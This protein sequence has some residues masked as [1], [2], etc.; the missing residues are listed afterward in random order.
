MMNKKARAG[1]GIMQIT[2]MLVAVFAFAFIIN[3]GIVGAVVT[4]GGRGAS[5]LAH[6]AAHKVPTTPTPTGTGGAGGAAAESP[7]L[8]GIKGFFTNS[9]VQGVLWGAT[10]AIIVLAIG[11]AVD[12][13]FES[14]RA[15]WYGAAAGG[16][17]GAGVA[18]AT[19]LSFIGW[20]G[21]IGAAIAAVVF[22][23]TS[24][25][26][27]KTE[28]VQF[29]CY[30]WQA[31]T[32]GSDC[33]KCNEN[34]P[35]VPCSEYRCKSLGQMCGIVNA[36]TED[37]K[38]IYMGRESL[39]PGIAPWDEP[40][41]AGYE[42]AEVKERPEGSGSGSSGMKIV[43]AGGGCIDAF[44]AITFGIETSEPAQC[45]IDYKHTDNF[46]AMGYYL[47]EDNLFKTQHEQ[48]VSLPGTKLLNSLYPEIENDGEY[49]LFIRCKDGN[50]NG[51]GNENIDEFVVSFCVDDTPDV[52]PPV[53]KSTSIENNA[54]VLFEVDEVDVSLF[55]NE[56]AE[57]R[58]DRQDTSFENMKN[59]SVS[60][61]SEVW[62]MNNDLLYPCS[63]TLTGVEDRVDNNFYFRCQDLNNNTMQQSYKYVLKGTQP[64]DILKVGPNKTVGGS[65]SV[66]TV[67]LE[68]RTDNG[69]N[70]GESTCGYS[71][72]GVEGSYVEM[73]ETGGNVHK[74]D[75]DLT[76]GDYDIYY[77]CVDLGGNSAEDQVSFEV[78]VDER[79][80]RVV[81]AYE[82]NSKLKIVTNEKAECRYGSEQCNY[83][84]EEGILMVVGDDAEVTHYAE[85]K[86]GD[87]YYIK[88]SDEFGNMPATSSCSI[89]VRPSS[90]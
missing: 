53:I 78:D 85:W 42:Y 22:L 10:V 46:D 15:A 55:I 39:S 48:A 43:K 50:E 44:T 79:A 5:T 41:T 76:D 20:A 18:V 86:A 70:N 69:F 77:K 33:E 4:E 71:F 27:A 90:I 26:K 29:K 19:S 54:P 61:S 25:E 37:E 66:V 52:T 73:F 21:I 7:L 72:T 45:K 17:V 28:I 8:K 56:P 67:E 31:P 74:Q 68:V 9:Y 65:T 63:T 12:K 47:G 82:E 75:L 49:E 23:T 13:D 88:C 24:S 60:C 34:E 58:W 1:I 16:G 6:E 3:G 81:R 83:D 32:G 57:C 36:G 40:L 84:F 51:G 89:I 30:S 14:H 38:C 59:G 80:P 87:S 64:L 2:I 62:E 35:D 11:S